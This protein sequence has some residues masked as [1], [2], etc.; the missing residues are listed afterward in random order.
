VGIGAAAAYSFV[1]TFIILKVIDKV[2][3]L[4]V[5]AVDEAVG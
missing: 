2:M 5:A 3:G 4:R 1:V